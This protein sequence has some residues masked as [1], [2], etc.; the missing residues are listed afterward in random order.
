M[1]QLILSIVESADRL[2][3]ATIFHSVINEIDMMI[4]QLTPKRF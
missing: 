2:I 1:F 4:V 3:D